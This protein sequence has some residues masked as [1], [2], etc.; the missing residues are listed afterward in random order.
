MKVVH[1]CENDHGGGA[2]IASKRY[3]EALSIAGV[4]SRLLIKDSFKS[5]IDVFNSRVYRRLH[6]DI[7]KRL[8]V[9]GSFSL[10][11]FGF[12]FSSLPEVISADCVILHWI[13]GNTLSI[14]GVEKILKSGKPVF[15]YMHDMF[16]I[17]GGC[18]HSLSCTGY[19]T[20]CLCCPLIKSP[21]CRCVAHLQLESKLRHWGKYDNLSF[22]SPSRWLADC[23][24][25][26][27][28]AYGHAIYVAPNV[29][30]TDL[31]K[32]LPGQ[33][34]ST[35]GL[36][37]DKRTVLFGAASMNSVYKGAEHLRA[38]LN[39]LDP[40]RFEGLIIG[41]YSEDLLRGLSI[42]VKSTGYLSDEESLVKAY[43]ACDVL[44]ITSIA[45]NY[46]NIVLEAMACGKPCVGYATGGIPELII[47]RKSGYVT[48]DNAPEELIKGV[49]FVLGDEG[50]Y[51]T[52]SAEAR[53]Q[54]E[55]NNSYKNVKQIHKELFQYDA[56]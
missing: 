26:S 56:A 2:A 32:P 23:V 22:V 25:P 40:D 1:I 28:L 34:K 52:M 55:R 3:C 24:K 48:S 46:P 17:T 8:N 51:R 43:N 14:K 33:F 7:V 15:W 9:I 53:S 13:N 47:N 20:E 50:R 41:D 30:D 4:D 29:I 11:Y 10:M 31:Y 44:V 16:P 5:N 38:F 12:D 27:R 6:T 45:E 37:P 49:Q 19:Q 35:F 21:V 42:T 18:H 39:R 54:I 36:S